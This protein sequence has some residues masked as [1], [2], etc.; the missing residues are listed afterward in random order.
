MGFRSEHLAQRI[1]ERA[2]EVR[3]HLRVVAMGATHRLAD[4]LVD[5]AQ[6]LQAVRGDAQRL[7][8]VG[9]PL[10]RLPQDRRAALG[11]DHRV[12][13]V[14][15]H[16]HLVGHADGQRAARAALADDGGDDRHLE[17]RHLEDVAAD[18]FGLAALLGADAGIGAGRVDEGEHRQP[19][20]LGQLHQAQRL[21][22]ALGPRHAE[23]AQRRAPW[24]R[25]PSG[26]PAPCRPGR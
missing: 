3:G 17:L 23:V 13:R 26:G 12:D 20:L 7:G 18:G 16:Q 9:R 2:L 5:Q 21:A 24:C 8:R 15:Q 11:R 10:G 14:L 22:V 19:E 6:R 4:D 1:V 25:G